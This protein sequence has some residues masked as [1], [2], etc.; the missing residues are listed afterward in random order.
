MLQAPRYLN[1]AL[2]QGYQVWENKALI[3]I[4]FKARQ[5]RQARSQFRKLH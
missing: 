4:G 2:E 5:P 1:P 3:T